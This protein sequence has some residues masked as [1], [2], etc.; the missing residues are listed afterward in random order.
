MKIPTILLLILLL[1]SAGCASSKKIVINFGSHI[2]RAKDV[3]V[4]YYAK[5]GNMEY[6]LK[7]L[8]DKKQFF[9]ISKYDSPVVFD[10]STTRFASAFLDRPLLGRF[11]F[12]CGKN[13]LVVYFSGV[14]VQD[15]AP[16]KPIAYTVAIHDDGKV[17]DD[18]GLRDE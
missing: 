4:T 7:I 10:I 17:G 8:K 16:P 14:Q 2:V 18:F 1:M 11:D 15:G 13:A 9:F 12:G 6:E 5:C 3:S